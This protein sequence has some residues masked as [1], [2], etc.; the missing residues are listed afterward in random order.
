MFFNI[1]YIIETYQ[2]HLKVSHIRIYQQQQ[3]MTYF[4]YHLYPLVNNKGMF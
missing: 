1:K 3:E 2:L 4:F